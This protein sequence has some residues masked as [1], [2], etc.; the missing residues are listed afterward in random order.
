METQT[1]LSIA[2]M[3]MVLFLIIELKHL[4]PSILKIGTTAGTINSLTG[5]A[6]W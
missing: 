1:Y 3:I 6:T 2:T 5:G 4:E